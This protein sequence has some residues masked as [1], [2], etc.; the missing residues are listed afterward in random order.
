MFNVDEKV[1]SKYRYI[2]LCNQRTKQLLQGAEPRVDTS[3]KK[4]A[5]IAMQEMS[6]GKIDWKLKTEGQDTEEAETEETLPVENNP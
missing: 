2:V 3:V 4:P 1:G 5:Y 6:D